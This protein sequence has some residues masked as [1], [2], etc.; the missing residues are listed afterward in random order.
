MIFKLCYST[1]FFLRCITLQYVF[2]LDLKENFMNTAQ[3]NQ[4]ATNVPSKSL[5]SVRRM[6]GRVSSKKGL[7]LKKF[8]KI[9]KNT[10]F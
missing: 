1:K 10:K 7:R 4:V 6:K 8:E 3:S 5:L 9:E 2:I